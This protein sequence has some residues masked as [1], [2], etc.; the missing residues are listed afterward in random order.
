[1]LIESS[2]ILEQHLMNIKP[3]SKTEWLTVGH[4][5]CLYMFINVYT[6]LFCGI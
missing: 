1:M 4:R 5:L 6:V 2:T 3:N